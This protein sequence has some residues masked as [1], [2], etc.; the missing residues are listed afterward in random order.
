M[1]P[2]FDITDSNSSRDELEDNGSLLK[3]RIMIGRPNKV[4]Q[5]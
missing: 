2:E 1:K 3:S 4:R 5:I